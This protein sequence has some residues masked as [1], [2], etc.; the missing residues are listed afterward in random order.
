METVFENPE[1]TILKEDEMEAITGGWHY[2]WR[3]GK[4]VYVAD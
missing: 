2:E 4:L 1:I 3:D